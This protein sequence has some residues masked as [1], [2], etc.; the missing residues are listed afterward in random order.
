M[1]FDLIDMPELPEVETT[2][3]GLIPEIKGKKVDLVKINFPKLRYEIPLIIKQKITNEVLKDIIR[4]GKYLIFR[5]KA[6]DL[7]IHLGMS[8]KIEITTIKTLKKHDHF[9]LIFDNIFMRLNDPRRF[10]CVLWC[11]D[12]TTHNLIK[13]L[14]IEPL[15]GNFDGKYLFEKS[16]TKKL[17]IKAFIMDSKIVVGVGNIYACESLFTA[18]INPEKSANSITKKEYENLAKIIIS[19]LVEA[20]KNGGTTLQDFKGVGGEL[21]YFAQKLQVYGRVNK[22]CNQ[23]DGKITKITQNQRSTFYCKTCQK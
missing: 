22:N 11:D 2:K 5:F 1:I 23:C 3:N 10:G 15:E 18:K 21:G 16:R 8:G 14:G 7:I 9:E 12:F 4:R 20:I 13:N 17:N 19:I 6:G